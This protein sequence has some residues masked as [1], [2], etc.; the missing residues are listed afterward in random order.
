[1]PFAIVLDM[2]VATVAEARR[3]P[4]GRSARVRDA[5]YTA[6][7]QLVGEGQRDTMTIPQVAERAG[8]NPTSIYRRWGNIEALLEEV[9]VAALTQDEPLPDTGTITGDLQAWAAIIA[10]DIARPKRVIYLR[11]MVAARGVLIEAC[12]CTELRTRQAGQMIERARQ[13]GERTPTSRQVVDHIIAPLYHHAVFG[14]AAGPE[15]AATLVDD[16]FAM[17]GCAS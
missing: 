5:V 2:S 4:G 3:R 7:G 1:M 12:P 11:A 14:L 16:V 15:Y 6:V 10:A 9:A 8:V 17:A 13:R